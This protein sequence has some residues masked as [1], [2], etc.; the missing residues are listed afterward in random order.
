MILTA[1][2]HTHTRYS[3]GKGTVL[4]NALVAKEKGLKQIGITDHG[5]AHPIFGLSKRKI[6]SLKKDCEQASKETGVKVLVGIESNVTSLQGDV[7]L[8]Q[9]FY[10][11]FDIFLA[12]VHKMIMFK[13]GSWSLFGIPNLLLSSFKVKNAP[14][15]LIK[16]STK[17]LIEVVK[18]NPVDVI[19]HVNFC[20]YVDPVEIAKVASDYGTYIELN[21][22]KVHI[23]D[24]QLYQI[25]KTGVKFVIDSDAHS[26]DRVGEISLVEKM[27]SRVDVSLDRIDNID[28]RLPNFR[29][30]A[31]KEKS[32]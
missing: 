12:G 9:K 17:A 2:Y 4:E 27:L 30:S 13:P 5:F 32:L 3:H 26:P 25:C 15:G 14:K 7:D 20:S 28:G 31:F 1:D 19:T 22:K 24:E 8:K 29:F 16:R 10:D 11:H 23:S 6:A 18:K 21:A